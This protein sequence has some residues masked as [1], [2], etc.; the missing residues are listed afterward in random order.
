LDLEIIPGPDPN[1]Q[2]ISDLAGSGCTTLEKR[3]DK[4]KTK[5]KEGERK[6][7][8]KSVKYIHRENVNTF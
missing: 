3:C 2:I 1:L 7:E 6:I 4:R 5:K 8:S